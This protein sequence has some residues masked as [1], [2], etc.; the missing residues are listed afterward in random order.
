[1]NRKR[2]NEAKRKEQ[3]QERTLFDDVRM[4]KTRL[5]AAM[6]P[7][8]NKVSPLVAQL[9]LIDCLGNCVGAYRDETEETPE[10]SEDVCNEIIQIA[11]D[12]DIDELDFANCLLVTLASLIKFIDGGG[13]EDDEPNEPEVTLPP[14]W[15]AG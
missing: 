4:V 9:A 15:S 10:V 14:G 3:G 5:L 11:L 6:A 1:M 8:A 12:K 13:E 2:E 7:L